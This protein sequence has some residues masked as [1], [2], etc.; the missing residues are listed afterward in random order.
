M[1]DIVRPVNIS[2]NVGAIISPTPPVTVASANAKKIVMDNGAVIGDSFARVGTLWLPSTGSVILLNGSYATTANDV[3]KLLAFDIVGAAALTLP[4][5]PP[6]KVWVVLVEVV[7]SGTLSIA[8]PAG[9][10]IDLATT[11]INV[12]TN[13]GLEI[14]TDGTNYFTER[15]MGTGGGGGG[16]GTVTN[17]SGNLTADQPVFGNGGVDVK[18]GTKSGNT[19]EVATVSGAFVAGNVVVSDAFGNLID[20]GSAPSAS[21]PYDVVFSPNQVLGSGA[22]YDVV[23]FTRTVTFPGNFSGSKGNSRIHPATTQTI[24]V[25]K[26]GTGIGTIVI[27]SSGVFSFTTTSGAVVIY[28]AGD[29]MTYTNQGG[30]D[31]AMVV[32]VTLSGTR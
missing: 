22:V 21:Q 23:V 32:S 16:G 17:T 29:Y 13:Q 12:G 20:G 8:P 2:D 19:D 30:A 10:T 27:T 5:P 11:T 28:N 9:M 25:S 26:N 3:G 31:G 1:T 6:F 7:G 14:W 18:V 24:T 15:G 4:S